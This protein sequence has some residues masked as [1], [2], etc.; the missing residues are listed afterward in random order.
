MT[1]EQLVARLRAK[2]YR[3]TPQRLII[4]QIMQEATGHLSPTEIYK[5]AKEILPGLT[6]ATVY[7]TL[8]FLCGQG[9]L[10]ACHV[11]HGNLL[12]E[13]ADHLHHHLICR[14]CNSTVEVGHETFQ[15]FYDRLAESTGFLLDEYHVTLFGLCP[16][17]QPG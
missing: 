1:N 11:G 15:N 14:A 8:N 12:Y 17:C 10:M 13:M 3:L 9:V 4:L 6:E 5:L 16:G 2:A 7:R